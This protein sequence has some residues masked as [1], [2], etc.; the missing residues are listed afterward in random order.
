MTFSAMLILFQALPS[1]RN[2]GDQGIHHGPSRARWRGLKG[3]R[4]PSGITGCRVKGA[5]NVTM[6][7]LE[8]R[9]DETQ[10]VPAVSAGHE[11]LTSELETATSVFVTVRPRLFGIALRVLDDVGEAEEVVQEA[12]LRWERADRSVVISPTAFLAMTT[13]RLAINV[14]QSARKRRET[15]TGSWLPDTVDRGVSPETA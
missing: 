11:R 14:T 7:L 1:G 4:G 13:T 2:Q 15:T 8:S 3:D 9:R 6:N 10:T 12:W 5:K